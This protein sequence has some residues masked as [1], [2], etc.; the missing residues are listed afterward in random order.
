MIEYI[1]SNAQ[2]CSKKVLSLHDGSPQPRPPGHVLTCDCWVSFKLISTGVG[3]FHG[4]TGGALRYVLGCVSSLV[5]CNWHL[6]N[7]NYKNPIL[8][9]LNPK[10]RKDTVM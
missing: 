3:P 8:D 6:Y 1:L 2:L 10:N 5:L 7:I 9:P 4:W